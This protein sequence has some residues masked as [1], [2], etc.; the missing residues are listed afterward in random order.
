MLFTSTFLRINSPLAVKSARNLENIFA[1]STPFCASHLGTSLKRINILPS[2]R[3]KSIPPLSLPLALLSSARQPHVRG[4][5]LHPIVISNAL[6]RISVLL[7]YISANSVRSATT[8][9]PRR[10]AR[11]VTFFAR[12]YPSTHLAPSSTVY[13]HLSAAN[14]CITHRVCRLTVRRRSARRG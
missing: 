12:G 11:G 10:V 7:S 8:C 1:P 4:K 3:I 6:A 5:S 13:E 14:P 2:A 9:A